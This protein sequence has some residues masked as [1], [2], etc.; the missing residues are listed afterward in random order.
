MLF[1]LV[2]FSVFIST[3]LTV[4]LYVFNL[5]V[6]CFNNRY[7]II[8]E[9]R[10]CPPLLFSFVDCSH[11]F[12]YLF[13]IYLLLVISLFSFYVARFSLILPLRALYHLSYAVTTVISLFLKFVRVPFCHLYLLAVFVNSAIFSQIIY[14]PSVLYYIYSYSISVSSLPVSFLPLSASSDSF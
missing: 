8:L 12:Y 7:W 11:G 6:L 10:T 2:N 4:L 9:F 1:Q 13:M 5:S 3:F 14:R